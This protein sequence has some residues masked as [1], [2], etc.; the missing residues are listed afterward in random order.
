[1]NKMDVFCILGV[2][3][4][5]FKVVYAACIRKSRRDEKIDCANGSDESHWE[6]ESGRCK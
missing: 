2:L 1:M 4:L 3:A 6:H 5:T